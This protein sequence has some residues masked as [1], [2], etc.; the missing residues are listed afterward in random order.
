MQFDRLRRREFMTLLGGAAS[1]TAAHAQQL[2]R[3]RRIGILMHVPENDPDGHA[4]LNALLQRLNELG[5]VQGHNVHFEVR[6]GPDDPARYSRQA[7]ELVALSP[8]IL[9]APTSFTLA[10]LQRATKVIPIVFVGVI[11]PVGAGF[12]SSL[13]KPGGNT[14]GFIAFEY[15]IGGKWLQLLKEIA[16]SVTRAAVLRDA[17]Y[18]SGVG[19]FAAIQAAGVVGIDLSVIALH[20]A[21][22]LERAV[23]EYAR[24]PN[25]GLIVTASPFGANH[26]AVIA[27]LASRYKLPAVYPFRYF[28]DAGGLMSYGADLVSQSRPAADYVN[29]ILNGEKPG[30]LPVQAPTKYTLAINLMT[31][32]A[33]GLEVPP[34][35]VARADE[36]VE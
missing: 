31:A 27:G 10:S 26:P 2:D 17:A 7:A 1:S 34:T 35:L 25:G 18:A 12:V 15:T 28:I 21:L 33:L 8:D 29:R 22:A 13:A 30:D 20:D 6:W 11:D 14:T 5:W 23:M 36:V 24:T 3:V 9:V 19:Q 4:R 16:P 32:R